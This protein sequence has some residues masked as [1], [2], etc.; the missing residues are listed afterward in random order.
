[1]NH[2]YLVFVITLLSQMSG[3]VR[4][5]KATPN[6]VFILADDLGCGDL[7]ERHKCFAEKPQCVSELR[8][9]LEKYERDGRS[10]PGTPQANDVAVK[11]A[12]PLSK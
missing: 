2:C 12:G 5:A 9:L 7:A 1:M 6:I 11:R 4:A 10:T 8:T 3:V